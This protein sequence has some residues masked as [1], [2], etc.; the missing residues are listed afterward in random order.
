[1]LKSNLTKLEKVYVIIAVSTAIV[2]GTCYVPLKRRGSTG[3]G[4]LFLHSMQKLV[5]SLIEV[6][7]SYSSSCKQTISYKFLL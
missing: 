3:V 1:M 4:E 2:K 5:E 6:G 7:Y